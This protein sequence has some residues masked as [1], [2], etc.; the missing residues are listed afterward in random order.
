MGIKPVVADIDAH[1]DGDGQF[2]GMEHLV[3]DNLSYLL[4]FGAVDVKDEFVVYLEYH[5]ALHM[6]FVEAGKDAVHG[7][8]YHVG[9]GAL[10]GHVDGIAFGKGTEISIAGVDVV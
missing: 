3:F 2:D 6:L 8:L 1:L 9:T 4:L 10:D 7:N 5:L